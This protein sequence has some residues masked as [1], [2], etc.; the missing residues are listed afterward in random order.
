M[1]KLCNIKDIMFIIAFLLGVYFIYN[2]F[3][4]KEG[5][6]S[7]ISIVGAGTNATKAYN[8][9]KRVTKNRINTNFTGPI[10]SG[11]ENFKNKIFNK[12]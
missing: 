11:M 9:F 7:P 6:K 1:F 12:I 3:S 8:N 5:L 10:K 2:H 4:I